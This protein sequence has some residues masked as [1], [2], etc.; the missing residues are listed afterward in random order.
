MRCNMATCHKWCVLVQMVHEALWGRRRIAP[1][2]FG[3]SRFEE[4]AEKLGTFVGQNARLHFEPMIQAGVG[5]ELEQRADGASF[6]IV[7]AIHEF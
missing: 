3:P 7:A 4:I 5:A 1:G 2:E 6:G